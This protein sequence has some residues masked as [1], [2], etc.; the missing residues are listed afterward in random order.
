MQ[1]RNNSEI[2]I[3]VVICTY[4]RAELLANSLQTICE[5]T[6]NKSDYE[7]LVVDN[8][9]QDSTPNLTKTFC[10]NYPNIRYFLEKRQGLSH[11]RNRGWQE[12]KGLYVAYVDDDCKMPIQWLKIAMK[13][14][15]RIAPAAF[16]GP[17]YAFYNSPK[18]YWWKDS[19][20]TYQQSQ[21]PR[22]LRALEYLKGNNIFFRRDV[23]EGMDGFDARLGMSDKN[24]GYHEETELQIRI[25]DSMPNELIYYDPELHV[26]HLVRPE[27]M[28]WRWILNS[29][30]A[31]GRYSYNA[32]QSLNPKIVRL[33]KLQLVIKA[34]VTV[35]LFVT[36]ILVGLLRYDRERYPYLQN[37]LYENTIRHM[38]VLGEIYEQY[39]HS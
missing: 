25:R 20:G 39:I 12:A 30:L 18:P 24:L 23:L 10:R 33:T 16:G 27:T 5:Q 32:F 38:V 28:T 26:Y 37:C 35:F 11:A 7:V 21:V 9:S 13:I 31:S 14:I 1:Y 2:S 36:D 4:N 29:C 34:C 22:P 6:I 3:S 17:A 15:D 19:Y 8:N